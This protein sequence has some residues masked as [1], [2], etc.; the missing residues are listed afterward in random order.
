LLKSARKKEKDPEG[1]MPLAEHL[2]ELRNRLAKAMLAL[3]VV[4]IGAAYYSA[5]LMSFLSAPVPR[6]TKGLG[7]ATGGSCAVVAYTDLLSPFTTTVKVSVMA[8]V[9]ISS[10]IWLYQ[11]WAFVAP[12]LH[13]H[14]RKYTYMFV[15]AA[16]PLFLGGAWLAYTVMPISMRVLLGITPD[17][18]ANILPMDKILD[19]TVRMVLIF[20]AAFELPLLLVMIN[21]T[22]MVTGRRMLGWWRGVVMGVFVFGA[23]ATPT[24]D[25]VGMI[26]LAGPIV[27]LYFIA[28]GISML[29]DRRRQRANPDAELDDDE[30]SELDLTPQGIGEVETVSANR[31]LPEQAGPERVNGYDDVT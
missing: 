21:L 16:V 22:G 30:A 1:R 29:N 8:G 5:E 20:G 11:L 12:G 10:P 7:E 18:S 26:A 25:P 13:K 31:A 28:V 9:I 27:V 23:V 14:E 2:R 6:C 4:S 19:F 3:T 24:T 17:G 15:S